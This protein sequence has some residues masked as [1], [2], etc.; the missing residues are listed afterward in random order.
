MKAYLTIGKQ[1]GSTPDRVRIELE[2]SV[3]YHL[4]GQECNG[5]VLVPVTYAT[6]QLAVCIS[7]IG[8]AR[9]SVLSA[10]GQ[11]ESRFDNVRNFVEVSYELHDGRYVHD[12]GEVAYSFHFII[13]TRLEEPHDG[14]TPSA[15]QFS[16]LPEASL[17]SSANFSNITIG[18]S[19]CAAIEYLI[20]AK[21]TCLGNPVSIAA[22]P[23]CMQ[24]GSQCP[25][26]DLNEPDQRIGSAS[27]VTI[28]SWKLLP[29]MANCPITLRQRTASLFRSPDVPKFTFEVDVSFPQL[30]QVGNPQIIP[31]LVGVTPT[32]C[33][34]KTSMIPSELNFY[35]YP[36]ITVESVTVDLH[37]TTTIHYPTL[38]KTACL[39]KTS[40]ITLLQRKHLNHRLVVRSTA[41]DQKTEATEETVS[42]I[43]I[44]QLCN[45]QLPEPTGPGFH[46]RSERAAGADRDTVICA[47]FSTETITQTHAISWSIDIACS[48][49]RHIIRSE[50]QQPITL[51]QGLPLNTAIRNH[52]VPADPAPA[53]AE[54]ADSCE[55]PGDCP[56]DHHGMSQSHPNTSQGPATVRRIMQIS[57]AAAEAALCELPAY[58][59]A[60]GDSI[61]S[62]TD[63]KGMSSAISEQRTAPK[64]RKR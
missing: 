61:A 31:F 14:S 12:T 10:N 15:E 6:K 39:S 50:L 24:V 46:K 30:L 2:H 11:L 8:R 40:R 17:T 5:L 29:E 23:I 21:V 49:E 42:C 44:G 54:C 53:Y 9:T 38:T 56:I 7:F 27:E 45:M 43:D 59:E 35:R 37:S 4:P 13:P 28:Q 62:V 32:T 63:P 57:K 26:L 64:C 60:G 36:S 34:K 25:I 41:S 18:R 52:L 19:W 1:S 58:D 16:T 33:P 22:V 3:P 47:S 55:F 48:G 51:V 20:E